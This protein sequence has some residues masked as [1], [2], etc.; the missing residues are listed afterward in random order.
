MPSNTV[1][2]GAYTD[3]MG[4][5]STGITRL[6]RDADGALQNRGIAAGSDSPS[7]LRRSGDVIY[8]AGEGGPT[9]SAFRVDGEELRFLGLQDAAGTS[10]CS[11]GVVAHGRLL[12][13]ACY[14][15]GVVDVHPIAPDGTLGRTSQS[16]RATGTGPHSVQDGP[17]AHDVL[18]VSD[19]LVLTTDL[20]ADRIHLHLVDEN[21][22]TRTGAIELPPGTGP[23]DLL[24]H[25][26]GAIWV[27]GELSLQILVITRGPEGF[28]VSAPVPI[29]GATEGDHAA[30][31]A[32]SADG[33]HAYTGL[34]GSNRIAVLRVEEDGRSLRP[35]TF[36]DCGGGWPRHLV[37]DGDELLVANQL[38]NSVSSFAIGVDG[39]PVFHGSIA[40]P[41]PTYLLLG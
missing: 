18:Q 21:G 35:L 1:W 9:I 5:S 16:L 36:V 6:A 2:V 39:V 13:A 7:F 33:R 38:S 12:V 4:G 14:G 20:G 27:L 3:D 40:V 26:S 24:L 15:D 31:L 23:R 30:A 32:L 28:V 25:P 8:A 41:S 19:T 10:P 34:R 29:P 17:H 37:V 22:L 11:L